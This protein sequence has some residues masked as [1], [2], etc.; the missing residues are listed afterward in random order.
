MLQEHNVRTGFFDD[1]MIAAVKAQLPKALQP[2]VMFAY[3]SGWRVQSEVLPLEWRHVD[4]QNGEVRLDPG[5]TKNQAGRVFPFTDT[6]REL[7]DTLWT[8]HEALKKA[9]EKPHTGSNEVSKICPY[10]FQ[11]NG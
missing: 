7:F 4:R 3:I 2:I 10:V 5:T 8:E 9:T 11:R 1:E 6:L